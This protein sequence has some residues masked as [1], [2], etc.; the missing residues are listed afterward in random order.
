MGESENRVV[1]RLYHALKGKMRFRPA[2]GLPRSVVLGLIL[3]ALA[4]AVAA[5]AAAQPINLSRS[6]G[7]SGQPDVAA[8]GERLMVVWV[9]PDGLRFATR[10]GGVWSSPAPVAGTG[11]SDV[12]LSLASAPDG[13][14]DLVW[15]S[16]LEGGGSAILHSHFETGEWGL[17][18]L[19]AE[20]SGPASGPRVAAADD[21]ALLVAWTEC[22]EG[23]CTLYM[24]S[25]STT[26]DWAYGPLPVGQAGEVALTRSA[27]AW[28]LAWTADIDADGQADVLYMRRAAGETGAMEVVSMGGPNASQPVLATDAGRRPVVAWLAGDS[29]IAVSWL[30]DDSW[31]EPTTVDAGHGASGGP[32]LTE[33]SS[34]L[35][36]AW[37]S[38]STVVLARQR[39]ALWGAPELA[40]RFGD[41]AEAVALASLPSGAGLAAAGRDS[42][43]EPDVLYVELADLRPVPTES[44]API[45]ATATA[46][47]TAT[48]PSLPE[49][50]TPAAI[51][52][53]PSAA[54][55][56]TTT[57]TLATVEPSPS[58]VVSPTTT[59]S[60]GSGRWSV[61]LP[62]LYDVAPGGAP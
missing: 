44:P 4:V 59:A 33:S 40:L 38:G 17:P 51:E 18:E 26:G 53:S 34:G 48:E 12:D 22:L 52:P 19:V 13:G 6:P 16:T 10:T 46:T 27:D 24:A 5:Q 61:H 56:P 55:S 8:S 41:R 50:A 36:V 62:A 23:A 7:R 1:N 47:T 42:G 35:L 32:A 43:A 14:F 9:E 31:S 37:P 29:S 28:H 15:S 45:P 58:A 21:G 57:A 11:S 54:L 49:T 25:A 2:H 60:T 39:S 20:V 3:A 30:A